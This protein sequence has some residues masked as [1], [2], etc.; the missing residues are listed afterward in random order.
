MIETIESELRQDLRNLQETVGPVW[1]VRRVAETTLAV[2]ILLRALLHVA[3]YAVLVRVDTRPEDIDWSLDLRLG[4]GVIDETRP[5]PL[6]VDGL[7]R[8][9]ASTFV[10]IPVAAYLYRSLPGAA[11][12]LVL[13]YIVVNLAVPLLDPVVGVVHYAR[14][15]ARYRDTGPSLSRWEV[16]QEVATTVFAPGV[17]YRTTAHVLLCGA[18]TGRPLTDDEVHYRLGE[19]P[20]SADIPVAA[21]A[22]ISLWTFFGAFTMAWLLTWLSD[23]GQV[24]TPILAYGAA[25]WLILAGD[26]LW[27]GVGKIKRRGLGSL[28]D[29]ALTD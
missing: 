10:V 9:V 25:N 12:P 20:L 27:F 4:L 17:V 19:R 23:F 15:R 16:A 8:V 3:T 13:G 26:P 5:I 6:R 29:R 11:P 28:M 22:S 18:L 1:A 7:L 21:Q 24:P 2:G 14:E